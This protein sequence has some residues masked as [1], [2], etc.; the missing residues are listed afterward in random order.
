MSEHNISTTGSIYS[1]GVYGST[2]RRVRQSTRVLYCY[3]LVVRT[4]SSD[5]DGNFAVAELF[6]ELLEG[7]DDAREGRRHIGEVRDAPSN[8]QHL[9]REGR[10]RG[11]IWHSGIVKWYK[12]CH[13]CC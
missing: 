11:N 4:G 5:P 10:E 7:A 2:M 6:G 3:L 9:P 13:L 12:R 8:D 1:I